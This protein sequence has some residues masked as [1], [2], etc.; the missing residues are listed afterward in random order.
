MWRYILGRPRSRSCLAGVGTCAAVY[1]LDEWRWHRVVQRSLL[2]CWTG[3]FL[4]WEYKVRWSPDTAE[5][6]H[7]RVARRIVHCIHRNEGLYV[8][9]GQVLASVN[10]ILPQA[11]NEELR[12][13]CDQAA[14]M[15]RATAT[16]LLELELGS[17]V[18]ELFSHFNETPVASASVAQ[19]H[20]ATLHSG[21]EVAVKLQKHNIAVQNGWDLWMFRIILEVIDW[22]FDL[23]VRWSYEYCRD[24][25][26]AELDFTH[27]ADN[28][29]RARADLA[30]AMGDSVYIPKI[31]D[32]FTTPRVLVM[33]WIDDACSANDQDGLRAR[34]LHTKQV[35]QT[36]VEIFAH[37]IFRSGFVHCDPHPG[38]LLVRRHPTHSGGVHQIV[39][40]DHGLYVELPD[41]LRLKYCEFWVAMFTFDLPRICSIAEGWGIGDPEM[42][43][44]LTLLRTYNFSSAS[45][46]RS[47]AVASH[48]ALSDPSA[49]V[50]V[51]PLQ[52]LVAIQERL[53]SRARGV[54]RDTAAFPQPLMFV[55]RNMNIVRSANWSTGSAVDRV[56]IMAQF[57]A[58]GSAER[59]P[60]L[61]RMRFT[62]TLWALLAWDKMRRLYHGRGLADTVAAPLLLPKG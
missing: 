36:A 8:K 39:L 2:T 29:E 20:R 60:L 15:D 1:A 25:L 42:F 28:Q 18:T 44:N 47:N 54:L 4:L 58:A 17:P 46:G 37:Q 53:M 55:G 56:A 5:R 31:Y 41:E 10:H 50:G 49:N 57:A 7:E 52:D 9:F 19:V 23:P 24:Q 3:V 32:A 27:E 48:A 14:T 11:Y 40:I 45:A 21:E 34:G 61:G 12:K 6:H 16:R 13:C 43:A 59:W 33:E 62:C 30:K 51:I 22:T 35:M 26:Q 38:N